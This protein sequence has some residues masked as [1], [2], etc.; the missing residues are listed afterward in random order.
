MKRYQLRKERI[1]IPL[2]IPQSSERNKGK[3]RRKLTVRGLCYHD[4]RAG[5]ERR[6]YCTIYYVGIVNDHTQENT[7]HCTYTSLNNKKR[8]GLIL[9]PPPLPSPTCSMYLVYLLTLLF[10]R[11]TPIP[12]NH[13]LHIHPRRLHIR[14][15]RH[16]LPGDAIRQQLAPG[17]LLIRMPEKPNRCIPQAATPR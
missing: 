4:A 16:R 5:R 10:A 14:K 3:G 15:Q 8:G 6:L 17:L 13:T 12:R 7:T 1:C 2:L 9:S 11:T